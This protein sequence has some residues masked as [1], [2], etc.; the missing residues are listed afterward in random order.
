MKCKNCNHE[1]LK[2]GLFCEYCGVAIPSIKK[3]IATIEM[4]PFKT[5]SEGKDGIYRW[6]YEM[7]LWTN[8]TII[9]TVIK[10]FSLAT[11][12]PILVVI[13]SGLFRGGLEEALEAFMVMAPPTILVVSILVGFAYVIVTLINGGKYCVVFEMNK[14]GIK[15]IQMEKQFKKAQVLAAITV[16]LSRSLTTSGAAILAGSKNASYSQFSKVKTIVA[17]KKRHVI[18]VNE[19]LEHNQIYVSDED[20][21]GVLDYLKIHCIN[22]KVKVK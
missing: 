18:Y 4:E 1:I 19:N 12:V 6:V 10:V 7:N 5:I 11:A 3:R 8:P 16:L 2:D 14:K 21:D 15:H 13:L 17:K 9:I 20:F 22:A